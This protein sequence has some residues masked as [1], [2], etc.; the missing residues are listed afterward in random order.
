MTD[1]KII[2]A[3]EYKF[4]QESWEN[5]IQAWEAEKIPY[6]KGKYANTASVFLDL[7]V[8]GDIKILKLVA[9]KIVIDWFDKGVRGEIKY[10]ERDLKICNGFQL[11]KVPEEYLGMLPATIN[12][13]KEIGA[14][15]VKPNGDPTGYIESEIPQLDKKVFP[16]YQ[17]V[18]KEGLGNDE[19]EKVAH[20]IFCYLRSKRIRKD[21]A[22]AETSD[23]NHKLKHPIEPKALQDLQEKVWRSKL[24]KYKCDKLREIPCFGENCKEDCALRKKEVRREA[25]TDTWEFLLEMT[26]SV[27]AYKDKDDTYFYIKV[28][29]YDIRLDQNT[30][31]NSSEFGKQFLTKT[32]DTKKYFAIMNLKDEDWQD[33]INI[34]SENITIDDVRKIAT[35]DSV[36]EEIFTSRLQRLGI[37]DRIEEVVDG[38]DGI[39]YDEEKDHF[40]VP[41]TKV[42]WVMKQENIKETT[43][44]LKRIMEDAIEGV[45]KKRY[46][47]STLNG[48]VLN[49]VWNSLE[50]PQKQEQEGIKEDEIV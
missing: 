8:A 45:E 50:Q 43:Q 28:E 37:S 40:W 29:N 33:Y 25:Q 41:I 31:L 6:N 3:V 22:L 48:W 23:W 19:E 35:E 17:K 20:A 30:M 36:I 27:T 39:F 14:H 26:E 16:C 1:D 12:K 24:T 9:K 47:K 46:S 42:R 4:T 15:N 11:W 34:I 10:R 38:S 44:K 7:P 5:A 2:I 49:R 21:T 13:S 32:M 18:M